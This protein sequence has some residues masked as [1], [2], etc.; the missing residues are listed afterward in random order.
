MK[1]K[2]TLILECD[3]EEMHG[4][5]KHEPPLREMI[6][7]PEGKLMALSMDAAIAASQKVYEAFVNG[8]TTIAYDIITE[9]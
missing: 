4:T 9:E 2:I 5:L 1:M 3:E 8:P 6:Q 7:S